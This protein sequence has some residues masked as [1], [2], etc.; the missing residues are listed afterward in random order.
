MAEG[1]AGGDAWEGG[2]EEDS[3]ERLR[4]ELSPSSFCTLVPTSKAGLSGLLLP[5]DLPSPKEEE[6]QVA[7]PFSPKPERVWRSVPWQGGRAPVTFVS[8]FG[9]LLYNCFRQG[10]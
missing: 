2:G 8:S 9:D 5:L 6:L 7:S 1:G 10:F 4:P 3:V